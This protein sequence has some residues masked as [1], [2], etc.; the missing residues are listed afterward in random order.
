MPPRK[1][2]PFL[3]LIAATCWPVLAGAAQ[4]AD[5]R[6]ELRLYSAFFRGPTHSPDASAFL[7][8]MYRSN[9]RWHRFWGVA[10]DYSVPTPHPGFVVQDDS[11]D[12]QLKLT[13]L[14][15]PQRDAYTPQRRAQYVV[16]LKKQPDGSYAGE[17]AGDFAGVTFTA[18]ADARWLPPAR[19]FKDSAPPEPGEHPRLLVRKNQ[20]AALRARAQTD[21]GRKQLERM[22][23]TSPAH[24]AFQY[25]VTGEKQYAEAALA[26]VKGLMN[27]GMASNQYGQNVGARC[28]QVALAYD[29]C[30]DAWPEDFKAKV[31]AHILDVV[32]SIQHRQHS[33]G[34]HINWHVASNWSAPIYTGAAIG[35]L[36]LWGDRGP[37]PAK[38]IEPVLGVAEVPPANDYQPADK[39]PVAALES[40]KMPAEWL[41]AA[42]F[43]TKKLKDRT[44]PL[45]SLGGPAKARPEPGTKLDFD[46]RSVAFAPLSHEKDQ[47]YFNERIDITNA[48][49]RAYH[50]TSYF[51]TVVTNDAPRTMR[52]STAHDGVVMYLNGV[53]R[54]DGDFV[55][56]AKGTYPILLAVSVGKVEGWGRELT[57]PK[58]VDVTPEEVAKSNAERKAHYEHAL[59]EYQ[60]NLEEWKRSGGMDTRCQ[61][62]FESTRRMVY[63]H[64]REAVGDGGFQAEISHYSHIATGAAARYAHPYRVMFGEDVSPYP[65]INAYLVRKVFALIY[66]DG[67]PPRGQD[68]NGMPNV[69]DGDF[70][71][72]FPQVDEKYQPVMLWAWRRLAGESVGSIDPLRAFFSYPLDMQPKEP[73]GIMPQCW[74]AP[75]YGF[76]AFRNAWAG[77]DDILL[78]VFARAHTIGGWA[79]VN[80]GTFR[81]MGLGQTWAWGPKGRSRAIWEESTVWIEPTPATELGR[82]LHAGGN[83]D[84]SGSVTLDMTDYYRS[85][86]PGA[87]GIYQRYGN[88]RRESAVMKEG[89]SGTRAFAVDYS[90]KCGAPMLLAI[91]DEIAGGGKKTWVWQLK[92][93]G[94]K[95]DDLPHTKVEGSGFA[96]HKAGATLRATFITPRTLNISA[97]VR[98][99]FVVSHSGSNAGK[100]QDR[101]ISAVY[102]ETAEENATYLCIVT[103]GRENPPAVESAGDK[104]QVGRRTVRWDGKKLVIE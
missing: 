42:S 96:I 46:G 99:H 62:A 31:K 25:L 60:C 103:L 39:T 36:T 29:W 86:M 17:Y 26:P 30:Y 22:K 76:Y 23:G 14:V 93:F 3:A 13:L 16:T 81:L 9:G 97:G 47:G 104:V 7:C 63:L 5:G 8:D 80:T 90:G 27:S 41:Y 49:R 66:P 1:T 71:L 54:S 44:A 51:Y 43:T 11:T 38:P 69:D 89:P 33:V 67:G 40:G 37:E 79:G 35:A 19:K 74:E 87:R 73:A 4:P 102:A 10:G 15:T 78:Q 70:S 65:D 84:G 94:E 88:V 85:G 21:F 20:L 72:L 92:S 24:L 45:T 32:Y 68:I 28:E 83:P 77:G 91:R 59:R 12:D 98:D 2:F 58:L 50:S 56:L 64:Y 101:P 34:G 61:E 82:V 55:R 6:L 53:A 57:Q 95:E 48:T 18:K 100:K 75:T 52:V